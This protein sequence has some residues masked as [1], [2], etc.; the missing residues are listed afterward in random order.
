M[1]MKKEKYL[2]RTEVNGF[3]YLYQD[4]EY[5]MSAAKLDH[6]KNTFEVTRISRSAM[7]LYIMSL[8]A[9]INRALDSFIPKP[10]REF[11]MEKEDKFT[12]NDKWRLLPLIAGDPP[13]DIDFSKYPWSHLSELVKIRND[14]VHPKHNRT[15]Y[16]EAVSTKTW[17]HLNWKSIP[18][19]CGVKEKDLIY[20]QTKVPKDPYG[21]N[22][23]HLETVKKVVDDVVEELNAI[24][25][26]KILEDNWARNDQMKLF[27]PPGATLDD[28]PKK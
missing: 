18:K 11:V 21:F 12:I 8:E 13:I 4:A 10:L 14:Y 15:A 27:Y 22:I 20:G 16:Y 19:K 28:I 2:F 6:V 17:N 25:G 7:L 23:Q 24:M 26:G 5:L 3:H 9:L 1:P